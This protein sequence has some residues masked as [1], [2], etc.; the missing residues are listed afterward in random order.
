MHVFREPISETIWDIKYRYRHN[1]KIYDQ[2]IHDTW[3]RVARAVANNES[4]SNRRYWRQKF[5]EL[6]SDFN[7]LPGGRILAGAGTNRHVT[8]CNCFVMEIKQDSLS[9]IFDALKEGAL[10]LQQGG[11]IGY[12]FSV[13]RPRGEQTDRSGSTASGPVSFM[14]IWDSMS[15]IMQSSGS[16]RGAMMGML[17]CDHP[18]IEEFI[19]IKSDPNKLRQFNI[20]VIITD[21]FMNAV[22]RNQDWQLVFPLKQKQKTQHDTILRR[23]SHGKKPVKCAV[24]KTIKAQVLW[25]KII[26]AAYSYAEPGVIF[27]DTINR[28]N[29]LWYC[30][31]I[32]ATNP[33]GEIPLPHYGA[34]DLGSINLTQCVANPFGERSYFDW[35]KMDELV[36]IATRFLDNI[37]DISK[38][39]LTAQKKMALATRRIGLGFTGLAD[40]FVMLGISYGSVE[41]VNLAQQIMKKISLATWEESINL[42]KEKGSFSLF[43]KNQYLK[44]EFVRGLPHRLRRDILKYGIRNSHHNAIAPTGTISLLANNISNGIEP[45]FAAQYSRKVRT[46]NNNALDFS[47][48]SYS[49]KLWQEY[50]RTKNLPPAWTDAQRLKPEEHLQIQAA[51]QPYI[52]NAISK[53]INL[54]ENFPFSKLHHIYTTAYE[55][56][57]KGCTIYR[58]NPITGYIL[59]TTDVDQCCPTK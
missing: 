40:A 45:I 49:Y 29:P 52:D 13:L 27:E 38:Y 10:T 16:R 12:D 46:A 58:P 34:C 4:V 17:R 36:R 54:P 26:H 3:E 50:S 11:G 35:L 55:L 43:K 33:C 23:W 15:A 14:Q 18:D 6:L 22:A 24:F 37:I 32:T 53:T 48:N 47:V 41:A 5:I 8:L 57:L 42:A 44:G 56:G 31:W 51:V 2:T 1:E 19:E 59:S 25:K 28:M 30:E 9:G 7:F 20:S 39:P 21:E